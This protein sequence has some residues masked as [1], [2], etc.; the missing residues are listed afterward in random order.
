VIG[1]SDARTS[2]VTAPP[3]RLEDYLVIDAERAPGS[4]GGCAS[5][6]AVF[7]SLSPTKTT[8]R[9]GRSAAAGSHPSRSG[10][11]FGEPLG[12]Q[13][14]RERQPDADRH[15]RRPVVS[16]LPTLDDPRSIRAVDNSGVMRAPHANLLLLVQRPLGRGTLSVDRLRAQSDGWFPGALPMTTPPAR[17]CRLSAPPHGRPAHLLSWSAKKPEAGGDP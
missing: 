14:V 3:A 13:L 12:G 1:G 16:A 6:A 15:G 9:G 8:P 11:I 17:D 7:R 5:E 10:M 2:W 4:S